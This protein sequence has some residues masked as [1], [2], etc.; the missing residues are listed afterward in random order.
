MPTRRTP[1]WRT[2]PSTPFRSGAGAGPGAA[3]GEDVPG[4][5]AVRPTGS[6]SRYVQPA[7][8][9]T[10]RPTTNNRNFPAGVSRIDFS[11]L[12]GPRRP[13]ERTLRS[14]PHTDDRTTRWLPARGLWYRVRS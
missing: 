11:P 1:V 12:A 8:A 13:A 5:D 4:A 2:D 6:R 9:R 7:Y 10:A 14:C 3:L